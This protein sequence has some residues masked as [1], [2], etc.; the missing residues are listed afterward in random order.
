M[1]PH[2]VDPTA[3]ALAELRVALGLHEVMRAMA[4]ADIRVPLTDL[5]LS[6]SVA[7]RLVDGDADPKLR[8]LI[9]DIRDGA[10]RALSLLGALGDEAGPRVDLR[11]TDVS[12][13]LNQSLRAVDP[14]VR[15]RGLR[16]E[17]ALGSEAARAV[18]D[19]LRTVRA[20][21]AVL[22]IAARRSPYEGRLRVEGAV[23]GSAL[24]L[25]FL[26]EGEPLSR[27]A[28]EA[29]LSPVLDDPASVSVR[30]LGRAHTSLVLQ[31]G[32]LEAR[33]HGAGMAFEV[34]LPVPSAR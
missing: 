28:I 32:G 16:V 21:V 12:E 29:M 26:D 11:V 24:H 25:V 5:C 4:L 34:T 9:R 2:E 7:D 8:S 6:A 17:V 13:L 19:R 30:D 33:P 22:S 20:L 15:L 14:V 27:E 23:R 10:S 1:C 3:E 18:C 31:G